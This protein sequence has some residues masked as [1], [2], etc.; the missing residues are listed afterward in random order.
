MAEPN[1]KKKERIYKKLKNK[2]RLVVMN[3][4]SFEVK[5]S[6]ILSPLNV[7]TW[8]GLILLFLIIIVVYIVAFT[9]IRELIPGYADVNTR[10]IASYAMLKADSLTR[11]VEIKNQYLDNFRAIMQGKDP[12]QMDSL[13][14]DAQ[15]SKIEEI[16]NRPSREDSLMRERIESEDQYNLSFGEGND[17]SSDISHIFFFTPLNG[18][19]SAPFNLAE[20][21]YGVDVIAPKNE[22]IKSALDGSV[23]LAT[24]TSE[25]GHVIQVQHEHNLV[26]IYKHNSVLLKEVGDQVKAGEAIAIIGESGELTSGP[27]LH[28][29]IW[30]NGVPI[31]PQT[32]MIF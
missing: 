14:E 3:D 20:K 31:D 13:N 16:Q 30:N 15:G 6:M 4:D 29:E 11:E 1:P 24:W 28:F 17:L 18:L 22:A 9:P 25:T 8:G 23:I 32:I 19:V 2:F 26:S 5:F 12:K 27:H 10:R 7:F 21:H